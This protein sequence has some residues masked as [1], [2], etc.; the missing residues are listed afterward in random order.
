MET[1]NNLKFSGLERIAKQRGYKVTEDGV[2]CGVRD[3]ILKHKN[4]GYLCVSIKVNGKNKSLY[5]HRLQAYQKYGEDIY[6]EGLCV[7]HL[8][9]DKS[10]NSFDNIS[11]GTN[12]DNVMDRPKAERERIANLASRQTIKYNKDEVVQY[13]S[14]CNRSRK[15]TME[16]FGMSKAGLHYILNDRKQVSK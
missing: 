15:K 14:K 13:Y 11:I 10:D 9:G 2:F 1:H 12:R 7:R 16:H 8:N 6:Q 4:K 5:A 3:K